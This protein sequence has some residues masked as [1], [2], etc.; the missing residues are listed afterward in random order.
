MLYI[1]MCKVSEHYP[2]QFAKQQAI[3]FLGVKCVAK[4]CLFYLKS[5]GLRSVQS[6]LRS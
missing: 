6:G 2:H 3:S 4:F 1:N 5:M